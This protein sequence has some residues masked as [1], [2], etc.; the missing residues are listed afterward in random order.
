MSESESLTLDP[1]AEPA[2]A[3]VVRE[4][5]RPPVGRAVL[6][7]VLAA[8]LGASAWALMVAVTDH[9]IGIAAIGLGLL[10]GQLVTWFT[11]GERGVFP[12]AVS[13]VA[14]VV[15]LVAGKYAAF[16]Y[17]IHR[18]AEHRFGALGGRYYGYLSG[19]TWDLFH[20]HLSTEFSALYILWVGLGI[21]A[22]W[23]MVGP[24]PA[25]GG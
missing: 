23:R 7:G 4:D 16:A 15:A 21:A 12:A 11:G 25:T 13:A 17:V 2:L 8:V 6:A 14:V 5:P 24:K 20:S 22:A 3:G 18:D 10:A 9:S 1:P 19:H